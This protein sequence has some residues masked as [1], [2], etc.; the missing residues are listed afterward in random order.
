MAIRGSPW[1]SRTFTASGIEPIRSCPSANST[2]LPL[3][4]GAPLRRNVAIVRCLR[5]D[6]SAFTRA[7]NSGSADSNSDQVATRRGLSGELVGFHDPF[8]I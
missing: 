2:S 7:A 4:L 3:I 8:A 5:L 1:R 6:M